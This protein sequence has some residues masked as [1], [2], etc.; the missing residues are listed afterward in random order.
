MRLSKNIVS[1]CALVLCVAGLGP[2]L[3]AS[4]LTQDDLLAHKELMQTKLDANKE[5]L[6]KDLEARGHRIDALEK[7]MD[8]QVSRVSDVGG[9]VDRFG[10]IAGGL[11]LLITVALAAA[12]LVGYFSVGAKASREAKDAA[13][14]WFDSN[15]DK[16]TKDIDALK[17]K[18]AQ[19]HEEIDAHTQ[20][21]AEKRAV[22]ET[23]IAAQQFEIG[24]TSGLKILS[25]AAVM[26][27]AEDLKQQPE[28]SY[29]FE[30][31]NT[32][33]FAAVSSKN[34]EDAAYYWGKAAAIPNAGAEK[35]A[36]ALL[37]KG[38]M[39]SRLRRNEEAI[40]VYDALIAKYEADPAAALRELVANALM[41]KGNSVGDL[42]RMVESVAVYDSLIAKYEAD[43][44]APLRVVVASTMVNKGHRLVELNRNEDA[45]D[46][47][48]SLIAKY[49]ADPAV[50]LCLQI[51]HAKNGKGFT[52]L[53]A[54][55]RQW[56]EIGVRQ[57]LLADALQ[58]LEQA[59]V[60]GLSMASVLGNQAYVAWLQGDAALAESK[61]VAALAAPNGGQ[62][63]FDA[64]LGDL[65]IHPV[66]E[67][68]GFKVLIDRCLA[69]FVACN[70]SA[71]AA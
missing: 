45:F 64:T 25:S 39:L 71:G 59:L 33:A 30:D 49:E 27:L 11:G 40:V 70:G 69:Q 8:D 32:R 56:N 19:S 68:A 10:V 1:I 47:Y 43:S 51:A 13:K 62:T 24:K 29:S 14:E 42:K 37:N 34:L 26:S 38:V 6:Q 67:D 23:E 7:R 3:A 22:A 5:L 31:W 41:S 55:K 48:N 9:S 54:A 12:G 36:Q 16:L 21:V 52:L 65:M 58:L 20:S 57:K 50:A 4:T 61:F 35:A 46:V 15:S 2:A 18:V 17:V 66:P 44:A 63:I 53:C 60:A 28:S